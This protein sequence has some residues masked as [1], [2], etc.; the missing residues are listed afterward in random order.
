MEI[1]LWRVKDK[2]TNEI[3]SEGCLDEPVDIS[4]D[5]F[6]KNIDSCSDRCLWDVQSYLDEVYYDLN[7][8]FEYKSIVIFFDKIKNG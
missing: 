4:V 1:Y 3:L 5:K 2:N 7:L 6:H 8:K